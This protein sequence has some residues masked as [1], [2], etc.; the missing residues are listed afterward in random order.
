M[1]QPAAP[2]VDQ[3]A[4][5]EARL[6]AAK[7]SEAASKASAARAQAAAAEKQAAELAAMIP[8]A[9][10]QTMKGLGHFPMSEHP[11]AFLEEI[12]PVLD[13]ILENGKAA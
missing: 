6:Q 11:D 9:R 13:R 8:G 2:A 5:D 3:A 10:Y 1:T 12:R 7:A 4:V